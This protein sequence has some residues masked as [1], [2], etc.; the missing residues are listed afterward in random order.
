MSPFRHAQMRSS[1]R[2]QQPAC[3]HSIVEK[4][5]MPATQ[6][7]DVGLVDW[8][9]A[10]TVR[11]CLVRSVPVAEQDRA[12]VTAVAPT[13][14]PRGSRFAVAISTRVLRPGVFDAQNLVT[15][16]RAKWR[17]KL[18]GRAPTP[19]AAVDA[20]VRVWLGLS[21]AAGLESGGLL[22]PW[23]GGTELCPCKGKNWWGVSMPVPARY[24]AQGHGADCLQ[25]PLRSRFRQRL[26]PSVRLLSHAKRG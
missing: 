2:T 10:A 21:P 9:R 5:P 25:R 26:M 14:S 24:A 7:G 4:P 23:S 6:R 20:A 8:G 19:L 13:T 1:W 16:P 15:I 18:G 22:K 3:S 17:R 11:P 12:L